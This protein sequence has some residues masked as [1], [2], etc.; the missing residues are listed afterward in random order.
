MAT[1]NI[2]AD[3]DYE[4][5]DALAQADAY[6]ESLGGANSRSTTGNDKSVTNLKYKKDG[7]EY[8]TSKITKGYESIDE[9]TVT[10][11]ATAGDYIFWHAGGGVTEI[12]GIEFDDAS[13]KYLESAPAPANPNMWVARIK[14]DDDEE[15][16]DEEDDDEA[17]VYLKYDIIYK[18]KTS[19]NIPI[20][21]DP[22]VKFRQN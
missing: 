7:L 19:R 1:E 17:V 8:K 11:Y 15:D 13:F 16:D 5:Q 2:D 9:H 22:K 14:S 6:L 18:T 10:A 12:V 21:L 20:R 3:V 4:M